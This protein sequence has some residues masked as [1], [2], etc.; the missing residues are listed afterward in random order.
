MIK[1]YKYKLYPTRIQA[2]TLNKTLTLCRNLY[3]AALQQR[4]DAWRYNRKSIS[5][6]DQQKELPLLK[7]SF[8]E[9][10]L[11]CSHTMRDPLRRVNGAFKNFF[12]STKQSKFGYP[13]FKGKDR[14][15]SFTYTQGGFR[16]TNN[17]RVELSKIGCVKIRF[18]R[19]IPKDA[20]IKTCA[21]K[22]ENNKWYVIFSCE[23]PHTV[24]KVVVGR[25]VGVD[26]GLTDFAVLSDGTSIANPK[27]LKRS[28]EKLKE[29]QSKYSKGKSKALRRRLQG[30][31][32]KIAN[33]RADFQHKLSKKLVQQYDLIA[34]ED[35][36]IKQMIDGNTLNLQKHIYDAAWGKFL[37][38]LA[39]KA[40][41]AGKYAIA[42][43]PRGTTQ[44]CSQCNTVVKK[45][46]HERQHSCPYCGYS[47][48]RD[49]NAAQNIL[50]LGRSA[51][52]IPNMY[53][54]T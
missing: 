23:I 47:T 39:Y 4:I 19:P 6:Y 38:M 10:A 14:Y 32:R 33:Q 52:E 50:A 29:T 53:I 40:E 13:R 44:R 17:N 22:H 2:Q 36:N 9:Y 1:S 48:T 11:I 20:E 24:E 45:E 27:Y 26:V 3:N 43:N 30:L 37:F 18:S 7:N 16:V 51:V 46:L 15:N 34:Y 54:N 42:V 35:L 25:V 12:R 5:Y 8:P 21:V 41:Y 49:H 28:E 31:H